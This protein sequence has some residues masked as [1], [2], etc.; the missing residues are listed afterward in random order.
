[1]QAIFFFGLMGVFFYLVTSITVGLFQNSTQIK[2][3]RIERTAEVFRQIEFAI[4]DVYLQ[5][6][7]TLQGVDLSN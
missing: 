3:Q 2:Q 4:N 7:P 6:S 5:Q 1:M